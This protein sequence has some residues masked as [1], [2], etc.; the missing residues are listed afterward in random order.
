VAF[1]LAMDSKYEKAMTLNGFIY[2]GALGLPIEPILR[3]LESGVQ[4]VSLSGTGPS[5]VALV[6]EDSLK[7]LERVWNELGGKV[8]RT[9]VNNN[10]ATKGRGV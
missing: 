9:K 1:D 3:A 6:N 2:C 8:I 10:P 4:G 7:D 5:Y